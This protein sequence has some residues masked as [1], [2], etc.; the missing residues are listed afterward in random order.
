MED[1][2]P[3]HPPS[4]PQPRRFVYRS[5]QPGTNPHPMRRRTD[6]PHPFRG[7][8]GQTST[9]PQLLRMRVYLKLN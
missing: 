4:D 9:G 8:A 3:S 2:Q 6:I 5:I 7:I 1:N